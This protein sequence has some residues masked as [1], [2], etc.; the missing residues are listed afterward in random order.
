MKITTILGA[1][2]Q[3]IKAMP[4]SRALRR[5]GHTEF[6]IHTGQHYD[7]GMSGIFFEELGLDP[8]YTNLGVGSG[9]HGQQTGE[10]L[11]RIEK[12]LAELQPDW[13]LVYGDTNSTLAGAL[14]AAQAHIPLAHVEAGLRSWN[15]SMP[16]ELN[17][18]LTDHCASRL[19]CPTETAVTN[20]RREGITGGVALTGDTMY[21]AVLLYS[22]MARLKSGILESLGLSKGEF[23]LATIH[24]AYNTDSVENLT[25]I[26][27]A[28]QQ[29][30]RPVIFPVHP[31]TRRRLQDCFG[32]AFAER[33]GNMRMIEPLGYLDMLM[34]EQSARLILTDSGGIQKEAYFVRVPCITLRPETEWV[35]TVES[36]WNV[37]AGTVPSAIL[38]AAA[39]TDWPQDQPV[40]CFGNDHSAEK[41][42]KELANAA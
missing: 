38:A 4:V 12:V 8:P 26:V 11:M 32:D 40:S 3:F 5:A 17:R 28:L 19:F 27:E 23:H 7:H 16:E 21:D 22:E 1:R 42:V 31:R 39:R 6:I 41:I 9:S 15:R 13:V 36:G 20:L 18:V 25:Q 10:T 2:P 37:I 35:E 30:D 14:A 24:R 33:S 34:L 29:L